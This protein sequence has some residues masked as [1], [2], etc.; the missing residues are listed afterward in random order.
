MQIAT[1]SLQITSLSS[2]AGC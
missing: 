2:W 1:I